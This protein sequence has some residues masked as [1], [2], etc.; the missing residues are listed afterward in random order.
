MICKEHDSIQFSATGEVIEGPWPEKACIQDYDAGTPGK[1]NDKS[2]IY[3]NAENAS[4]TYEV[5]GRCE[6]GH[7]YHCSLL[8]S[9]YAPKP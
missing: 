4:A 2:V 3:F 5:D 1:E 8:K 7:A 9:E 6:Y